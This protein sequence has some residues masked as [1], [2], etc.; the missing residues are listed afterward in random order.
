[1]Q[2]AIPPG[3]SNEYVEPIANLLCHLRLKAPNRDEPRA[4][5]RTGRR[6]LIGAVLANQHDERQ[7]AHHCLPSL[8]VHVGN[9][10][11]M[12]TSMI[13]PSGVS[14]INQRG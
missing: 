6:R 5:T 11:R 14:L 12:E 4:R 10:H 3:A 13:L 2:L 8:A 7:V 1:M 9:Q